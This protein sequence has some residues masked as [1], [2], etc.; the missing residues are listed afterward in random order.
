MY[1]VWIISW[2]Y[3]QASNDRQ[4][5]RS[6]G[7]QNRPGMHPCRPLEDLHKD[8]ARLVMRQIQAIHYNARWWESKSL[9]MSH[10]SCGISR[11]RMAFYRDRSLL[12]ILGNSCGLSSTPSTDQTDWTLCLIRSYNASVCLELWWWETNFLN[13]IIQSKW[14]FQFE[15]HNISLRN[16][17]WYI[18]PY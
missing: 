5:G 17:F 4:H 10:E 1:Y 7:H 16:S 18:E 14:C 11:Y 12:E 8:F 13:I 6:M 2:L 9:F 15:H 3:Q